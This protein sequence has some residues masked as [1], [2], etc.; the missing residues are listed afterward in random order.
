MRLSWSKSV[1]LPSNPIYIPPELLEATVVPTSSG[2][3]FNAQVSKSYDY[4]L[5]HRSNRN[6]EI[7]KVLNKL[8]KQNKRTSS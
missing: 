4:H 3:P 7:L 2:L 6:D 5:A 8:L 1:N